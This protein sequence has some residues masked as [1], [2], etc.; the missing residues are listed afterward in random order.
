MTGETIYIQKCIVM[1]RVGYRDMVSIW[2]FTVDSIRQ[3]HIYSASV[4]IFFSS[5]HKVNGSDHF[6]VH[7]SCTD[8]PGPGTRT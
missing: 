5:A 3:E 8:L 7:T 4:P 2:K 6:T 1:C